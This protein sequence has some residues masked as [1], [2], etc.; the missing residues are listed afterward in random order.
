M[1]KPMVSARIIIWLL[2]L[3]EFNVTIIDKPGKAN[4]VTYFL[5]RLIK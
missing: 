3:K 5:S 2:L 1:N 4:V